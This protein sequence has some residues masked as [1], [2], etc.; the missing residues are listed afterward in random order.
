[1][2]IVHIRKT[3]NYIRIRADKFN[4]RKRKTTNELRID[5]AFFNGIF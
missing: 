5:M 1:M 2:Y 4:I 3:G